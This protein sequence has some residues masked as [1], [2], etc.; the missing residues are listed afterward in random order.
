MSADTRLKV[1]LCWHMHQPEYRDL[2]SGEYQLPWVYLHAIKDYVDMVAH[3]E[4]N[5]DARAVVNFAPVLLDQIADYANQVHQFVDNGEAIRDPLLAALNNPA[6]PVDRE[7]RLFLIK[8]CLRANEERLIKR[9]PA[10]QR[11]VDMATWLIEN[12]EHIDYMDDQYLADLLVWYHLAW[13]GET[14]RREDPRAKL[15]IK[16][17]RIFTLRDRQGLLELIGELLGGL[18]SRYK[19]MQDAGRVELSV[20][21]Y[22]HPIIPLMQDFKSAREALPETPLPL[23]EGCHD[24]AER[25][26]WHLLEARKSFEHYFG[27]PPIGCWPSE[28]SVSED[29]LKLI[30]DSG[31]S[32]AASGEAVL[33][34][35][36]RASG[37]KGAGWADHLHRPCQASK[38]GVPCFFRSDKLSDLIGFKF[39]T[40][41]ADDAVGNL[42]EQLE[43]IAA[44]CE[45]PGERVVSIIMDGENAWEHYPENGFYFLDA[46]YR[47]LGAHPKLELTTFSRCLDATIPVAPL[48]QLVAGSWVYGSFST[49][50]GDQDKNRGWDMLAEAEIA[51]AEAEKAGNATS[52]DIEAARW[53]LAA[54]EGSDWFWWFGDYNP[55]E[56]VRDFDHLYRL[57]LG[58][59]YHL[60]RVDRPEY[61]AHAFSHGGGD[62][63]SGGTMRR[64]SET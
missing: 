28:G 25:A 11:L 9:F 51:F 54:C 7:H 37:I 42:V 16:R 63:E 48:K 44:E 24:G 35:S 29:T 58:N 1:V 22:A 14:V 5:P 17:A 30:E 60:L 4:A 52:K 62:P 55:A 34:N 61:L 53:Q 32:W 39:A 33:H 26:R 43:G 12:P 46:L 40:W 27:V 6:L 31:F 50:I 20:T 3:I 21:P 45:K 18:I 13:L 2:I 15:L 64:G 41:H 59:L 49:W 47:R 10:Y 23:A 38:G 57:H 8:S 36:L 19:K 56:S